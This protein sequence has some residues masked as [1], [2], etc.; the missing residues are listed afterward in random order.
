MKELK[1]MKDISGDNREQVKAIVFLVLAALLWSL[2]G[3]LI[4]LIDWN[5]LAIAGVRSGIAALLIL[6]ILRRP[7]LNWSFPQVGGA[8][9]YA[10]TVILFVIAN[11]LTTAANAIL[12]QYTAPIY[13]ALFGAW[14][15]KE[16]TSWLDWL[17]IF[18]VLGG[19]TLFFID[20]VTTGG[21]L[22]NI[23][24][25]F[26]GVAFACLVLFMRKQKNES[27]LESVFWGNV[28]T[29]LVGLPFMFQSMPNTSSWIGLLLLG[30]FQLGLSY[31]LYS[32]AI[33]QVRALEAILI[34]VVEPI[35]NPVWVFLLLGEIPGPWALV[36]GAIVLLSVTARCIILA[37][38]RN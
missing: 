34:P 7:Q 37:L 35:L 13:V 23:L 16:K 33:K 25:I 38:R 29:A 2:G 6:T 1:L 11:K 17:T 28:L 24:A 30:I 36:G 5:P 19:M 20:D 15:L 31:I 32:I 3:I 27:P 4:K 22:G 9:S 8:I 26:S 18:F 12:L 21:L 10:V 14:F